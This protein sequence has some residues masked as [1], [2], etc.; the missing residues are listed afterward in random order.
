MKPL[1]LLALASTCLAGEFVN[2]TFDEPDL[3]GSLTPVFPEFPQT[4]LRGNTAEVLRGW[5]VL[6]G[7]Q[8]ASTV[9]YSPRGTFTAPPVNLV[10]NTAANQATALGAYSLLLQSSPPDV[11]V[12]RL[13][14]QGTIPADA[15]GLSFF[16]AGYVQMFVNGER[17]GDSIGVE[18]VDVSRWS[19]QDV[20]LEFLV[21]AG[22]SARFDILGW[23]AVPEPSTWALMGI[24]LTALGWQ[25]WRRR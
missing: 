1:L 21:R 5:T 25:A 2:L 19:G 8:P 13:S 7:N 17:A 14:Q 16:G 9:L 10:Q 3:T 20:N 4:Y 22:E 15:A 24:G 11:P 18:P 6:I 23:V 12:L